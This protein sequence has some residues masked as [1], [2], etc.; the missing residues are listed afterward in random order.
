[1]IARPWSFSPVVFVLPLIVLQAG[2]G[3]ESDPASPP[4]S[5]QPPRI[6][7][8]RSGVQTC[9]LPAGSIDLRV[10]VEDP[11][12]DPADAVDLRWAQVP[13]PGVDC[14]SSDEFAASDP[15]LFDPDELA[16]SA[17]TRFPSAD[18]VRLRVD[19]PLDG[20]ALLIAQ[21]RDVTGATTPEY[22]W[23]LNVLHYR[24]DRG[25]EVAPVLTVSW[26]VEGDP[27]TG[28]RI[29]GDGDG[30]TDT[31]V[32]DVAP[33]TT[34]RLNWL[35]L[36]SHYLSLVDEFRWG[37]DVS[38]PDDASDPGW[39]SSWTGT[40]VSDPV[41]ID[42]ETSNVVV[43]CRDTSGRISRIVFDVDGGSRP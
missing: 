5:S 10:K 4:E 8:W 31:G 21:A 24:V 36:A 9:V 13:V 23:A 30:T 22:E 3:S 35:G 16:W 7:L 17:W 37:V 20:P 1:M 32:L 29:V 40:L 6:E 41:T 2:C 11:D 25:R 43:Q 26:I 28:A 38:H 42:A 14:L 19:D 12:S 33:G 15:P 34:I 39:R 27:S 18:A